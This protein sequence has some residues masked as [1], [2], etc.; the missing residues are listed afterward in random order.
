MRYNIKKLFYDFLNKVIRESCKR[1]F[2]FFV[3]Y[4]DK[5]AK[6]REHSHS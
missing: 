2:V 6:F 5:S 1:F 3:D 4:R